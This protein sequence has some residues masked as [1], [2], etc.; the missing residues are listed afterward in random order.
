M[1]KEGNLLVLITLSLIFIKSVS[2][3]LFGYGYGFS[4]TNF[5][6]SLDPN[7]VTYLLLFFIILI[8][9][10]SVLTRIRI[11]KDPY[12]NPNTATAGI[13]SFCISALAIYYLYRSDFNGEGLFSWL[14]FSGSLLSILLII[15]GVM[16]VLFLIWKFK[17][18]GFFFTFGFLFII[19]PLFTDIIYERGT[20]VAIGA[21]FL[22]IGFIF[23]GI[24]RGRIGIGKTLIWTIISIITTIAGGLLLNAVVGIIMGITVFML[25][26][27]LKG[28][29]IAKKIPIGSPFSS[30]QQYPQGYVRSKNKAHKMALREEREREENRQRV[31]A[32]RAS[33][34]QKEYEYQKTIY[35]NK[36]LPIPARKVARKAMES[37]A[38]R[39][40]NEGIR[41][42]F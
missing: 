11:F 14:G 7:T 15:L 23:W 19:I 4:I 36:G 32:H 34:L 39:A 3:E 40:I 2:A 18:K 30:R 31:M 26:M 27:L 20:S 35:N 33:V 1:K 6:D 29:G 5:F 41:L 8:L 9:L 13:I 21:I 16:V 28:R 42:R 22:V 38:Q 24:S 12:G 10:M 37:I 25:G 17:L